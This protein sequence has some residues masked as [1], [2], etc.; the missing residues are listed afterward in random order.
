MKIPLETVSNYNWISVGSNKFSRMK[1]S[2]KWSMY[3]DSWRKWES[4]D[5]ENYEP[6]LHDGE[7]GLL[8]SGRLQ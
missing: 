5:K 2:K 3:V 8:F 1:L 4:E 7:H 6:S